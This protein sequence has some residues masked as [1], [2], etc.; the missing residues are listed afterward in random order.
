MGVCHYPPVRRFNHY[1]IFLILMC[2]GSVAAATELD[3]II[4]EV[5][6]LQ[7]AGRLSDAESLART[8]LDD[9]AN[10]LRSEGKSRLQRKLGTIHIDQNRYD[11]AEAI[12]RASLEN[13]PN[14]APSSD[15]GNSL[16]QLGR[17]YRYRAEFTKALE[18]IG[19]ASE[20]FTAVNDQT[21]MVSVY[22][23]Y[24][25]VYRFLGQLE[26]SLEWHQRSLAISRLTEDQTGVA[27]GLFNVASIHESLDEFDEAHKFYEDAL[28]IDRGLGN[29]RNIAYSHLR[30]G[31]VDLETKSFDE[32][33]GHID[34][35]VE[36]FAGIATPRDYQWALSTRAR[37]QSL[38]VDRE[39]AR[40]A[41]LEIL[42]LCERS[43]WPILANRVRE[44]LASIELESGNFD[45]ALD[46]LNA[47]LDDAIEQQSLQR[48]LD[49]YDVEIKVYEAKGEPGAAL[50]AM[51][52][53][54][55]LKDNLSDTLRVS[56]MA[57]IQGEVEFERQ[58]NLLKAAEQRNQI[59]E[60]SMQRE[61]SQQRT[62]ILGL[63]VAFALSFLLYGR[64]VAQKQNRRLE[65]E[66]AAK[67]RALQ[68]R[69]IALTDAYDAV[70]AA[71]LT[72]ALTG[73][74]NR[75]FLEDRIE[76]DIARSTR[77]WHQRQDRTSVASNEA[78]DIVFF[79]VDIDHFKS[80]N[81]EYG[82]AA[83][84][85][86]LK[87]VSRT[88]RT[89]VRGEDFV[90]RWGG[91]EFL[92]VARFIDRLT[93]PI[94]AEKLRAAVESTGMV[95]ESGTALRCTCSVGFAAFPFLGETPEAL[96]WHDVVEL[97]DL[98]LYS[99]KQAGRN[100]WS[101]FHLTE[102][103]TPSRP[104]RQWVSQSLASGLLKST[105][106]YPAEREAS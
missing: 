34:A 96:A 87:S 18:Y 74:E 13:L 27:D 51:R 25:V 44:W 66:V 47:A 94:I 69:N 55:E 72:D 89:T 95:L 52:R 31:M 6:Q 54:I 79:V 76:A 50:A 61:A 73:L 100:G 70:E 21:G 83:G 12:L 17:V 78:A 99:A 60:L 43:A 8:A 58:A 45:L 1:V 40:V 82:H 30:L 104:L 2:C 101:G 10:N 53:R 41:L 88:L 77:L 90:I 106:S 26:Q 33:K 81:D 38:T 80:I 71:S 23:T 3:D 65:E 57:A 20:Q 46:Y 28:E 36:L 42:A 49:L 84:D 102:P 63:I 32:A 35:A 9:P 39:A 37:L 98:A 22:N 67:T 59:N 93:A 64:L 11:D 92:I 105:R 56:V 15:R 48:V 29:K 103:A 14:T 19:L 4:A 86:V 24:G 62:L 16:L 68:E 5:D 7:G 91:E 85:R 97:A 75:R